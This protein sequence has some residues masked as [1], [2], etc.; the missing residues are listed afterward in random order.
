[1]AE[2]NEFGGAAL[3]YMAVDPALEGVTGRWYDTL[4]P[5]KH[6]LA[7]HPPSAEARDTEKQKALWEASEALVGLPPKP[8]LIVPPE[9]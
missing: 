4:P 3:A 2:S 1:M 9:P 6:Q 8:L 7:V 5:G